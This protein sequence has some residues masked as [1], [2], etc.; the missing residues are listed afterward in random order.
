MM[1]R[2]DY[3]LVMRVPEGNEMQIF[4]TKFAGWDE[5]MAVDF[6]RTA[7]SVAKTGAN[8]TQWAR[9]QETRTDLAALFMPRQS[10]MPL[11]EAEQ[12]EEEWNYDLE[13][14]EAFV[15]ENKKFVRLPEEE[16]GRFYT[17]E[18]YVFLCRYCIPI[19]EPEN[20]PEDGANPAADDSKSKIRNYYFL[21][22]FFVFS[23]Q[24]LVLFALNWVII[25][26]VFCIQHLQCNRVCNVRIY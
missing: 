26:F 15:L 18:C 25:S 12:L 9:Q 2:P 16:L 14:M 20:G 7:K 6:T 21:L 22:H 19:E 10:A 13:M 23:C 8:L 17:G 24:T 4:R 3:A 11:A 1:D 5:V